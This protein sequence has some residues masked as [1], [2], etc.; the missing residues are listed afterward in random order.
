[1]KREA[2]IAAAA[3]ALSAC[4]GSSKPAEG[5]AEKAGESADETAKE[6]SDKAGDLSND[7]KEKADD[8]KKKTN[9]EKS[10][11]DTTD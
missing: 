9:P 4:G 10:S 11:D 5:P 2:L 6:A 8:V 7:T 3:I 1:M